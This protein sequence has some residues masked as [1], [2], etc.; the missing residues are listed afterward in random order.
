M[1][2][3]IIVS[4]L[5]VLCTL[6]IFGITVLTAI[7]EDASCVQ[8]KIELEQLKQQNAALQLQN[9]QLKFG[10]SKQAED[11]LKKQLPASEPAHEETPAAPAAAAQ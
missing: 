9:A 7:A 10:V 5:I 11:E 1:Q 8:Q 6:A 2:L 4:G 3:R